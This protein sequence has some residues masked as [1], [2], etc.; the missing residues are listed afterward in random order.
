MTGIGM[1]DLQGWGRELDV[2]TDRI[3][4]GFI[5]GRHATGCGPI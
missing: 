3:V 4:A 5:A 1:G 2:V